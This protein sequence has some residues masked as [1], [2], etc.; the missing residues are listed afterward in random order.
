[1]KKSLI[2]LAMVGALA[3]TAQAAESNYSIYGRL[4]LGLVKSNV[5]GD[6]ALKLNHGTQSRL[7]FKGVEDLGNGLM[8]KF[9]IEHRFNADTGASNDNNVFWRGQA[10]VGLAGHF[11]EVRMGRQYD[12]VA[13]TAG[14]VDPFGGDY[15]NTGYSE[16]LG[17]GAPAGRRNN[18]VVYMTPNME[19]F[20]VEAHLMFAEQ[21]YSKAGSTTGYDDDKQRNLFGFRFAYENGPIAASLAYQQS[22][23]TD[24]AAGTIN[25]AASDVDNDGSE[26]ILYAGYTLNNATTLGLGVYMAEEDVVD[27]NKTIVTLGATHKV[28]QGKILAGYQFGDRDT[29]NLGATQVAE[30]YSKISVGYHH[31]MSDRTTMYVNVASEQIDNVGFVDGADADSVSVFGFGVKHNF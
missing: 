5:K 1:M 26:V 25:G 30:D 24:A 23:D 3:S 17:N 9:Q 6:D 14:Q 20:H 13:G 22:G 4:D 18:S 11:G 12:A 19:G 31:G 29:D 21:N 10:W 28:G 8:G 15:V 7:G 2:A 27:A 16:G